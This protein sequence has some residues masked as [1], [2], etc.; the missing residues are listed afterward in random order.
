MLAAPKLTAAAAD[1]VGAV[2]R[3]RHDV[4]NAGDVPGK[5]VVDAPVQVPHPHVEMEVGAAQVQIHH[6]HLFP[7]LREKNTQ[8]GD[9]QAF[10]DAA[11]GPAHGDYLGTV[12]RAWFFQGF[13]LGHIRC[14]M[15]DVQCSM[16]NGLLPALHQQCDRPIIDDGDRHHGTETAG[17]GLD[18]H[19]FHLADEMQV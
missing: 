8:V 18:T 15:L 2:F 14:S 12:S 6:D 9:E 10:P 7:Q 11:L 3:G 16:F 13:L 19:I 4:V 17:L 5:E 1:E